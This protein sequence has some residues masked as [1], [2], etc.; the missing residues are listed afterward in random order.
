MS[1]PETMAPARLPRGAVGVVALLTFY[2]STQMLFQP[3]LFDFWTPLDVTIAWL[4]YLLELATM[5]LAMGLVYAAVDVGCRKLRWPAW[6]RGVSMALAL[7]AVAV[8]CVVAT[9]MLRHSEGAVRDLSFS[10]AQAARWGVIAVYL[11]AMEAMWRRVRAIDAEALAA[12]ASAEAL[13]HEGPRLRLQ[14]LKAQIEPHFLFNTLAN[15]RRLYH[16]DAARG[17]QMMASLKRYLQA[18]LPGL[19]RDD[20]TLGDELALVRAYL[21]LISV[22]MGGRLAFAVTDASA[23]ADMSLP[24]MIVLTLVENAV[25]HGIEPS[26]HGGRID[27]QTTRT[28]TGVEISVADDGVGIGGAESSG[29]GVGLVNIRSQLQSRYGAAARIEIV[30]RERGVVA[31][32]V[33]GPGANR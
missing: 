17:E 26:P 13:L 1:R 7:Y 28:P 14:L 24:P 6:Q 32:V 3:H 27:V 33:I 11:V 19:R 9:Q 10:M 30:G 4:Q 22:R 18:T 12:E 5:A 15:V 29:S 23:A 16:T 25:K 2:L 20:A 31:T 8:A 21:E